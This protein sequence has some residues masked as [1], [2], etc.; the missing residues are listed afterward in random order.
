[1]SQVCVY[2]LV[3]HSWSQGLSCSLSSV[4]DSEYASSQ[5]LEQQHLI[6]F[7]ILTVD[8]IVGTLIDSQS[9]G[10]ALVYCENHAQV[11][12]FSGW[13]LSCNSFSNASDMNSCPARYG[14]RKDM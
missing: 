7:R 8:Q 5:W 12:V 4:H 1:M 2:V 6:R 3:L 14:Q 11:I 9:A 13:N 10:K